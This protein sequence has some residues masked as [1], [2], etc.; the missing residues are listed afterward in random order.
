MAFLPG[1]I[2]AALVLNVALPRPAVRYGAA[3]SRLAD[4]LEA[5]RYRRLL[6]PGWRYA[7]DG[8]ISIRAD[9]VDGFR[10]AA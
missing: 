1:R 2:R 10:L 8:V 7:S 5:D 4:G 3:A 9:M 6:S